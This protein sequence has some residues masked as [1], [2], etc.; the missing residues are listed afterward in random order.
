MYVRIHKRQNHRLALERFVS[1]KNAC[2]CLLQTY[3]NHMNT[4]SREDSIYIRQSPLG[5]GAEF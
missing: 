1:S 3:M 4:N 2:V 5:N